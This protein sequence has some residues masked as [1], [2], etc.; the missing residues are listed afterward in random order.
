MLFLK[1]SLRMNLKLLF[2][3]LLIT[4]AIQN[5]E[6]QKVKSKPVDSTKVM[7]Q[8][9]EKNSKKSKFKK[10]VHKLI[11]TSTS[12]RKKPDNTFRDKVE[13]D[14]FKNNGKIVRNIEI[15][16]LDPFGYSIEDEDRQPNNSFE[17][18]GNKIHVKSKKW[19]IR[20]QI[21]F[22]K[23]EPLDSFLV[24]E[25]ERL[26]RKQRFVRNVIIKVVPI[27]NSND[28]IDV[29]I[30]V[31]DS[32]SLIPNGS[33]SSSRM[34]IELKERN[35]AGLGHEFEN[36][37]GTQFDPSRNSYN[38]KYS[39]N[40]IKNSF[41]NTT[42][43][44][45]KTYNSDITKSARVERIFYSPVTRF[46]GGAFYENRKFTDSLPSLI[47]DFEVLTFQNETTDFWF[48]N[49]SKLFSDRSLDYRNTNFVATV[50]YKNLNYLKTASVALDPTQ[51]LSDEELYL[52][53]FG[54]S[55]RKFMQERYLFN[56]DLIEDVPFGKVYAIT[57]GF[58]NKNQQT[59]NYFGGKFSHGHFFTFGFLG[60]NV[61]MG[62]F[63]KNGKSEE[64]TIRIEA[65]YF[66]NLMHIG[67]WKV[68][69][70]IKPS[71]VL[72]INRDNSI[73][74][75]ISL[76]N[77]N[78]FDGFTNPLFNGDRKFTTIFQTQTYVPGA[79]KGFHFS[80]FVNASFGFLGDSNDTFLNGKLYSNFTLGVLISNDYLVFN[81]FQISMSFYPTIPFEGTNAFKTNTF[82]NDDFNLP[83]YSIGQ[84]TIVDFK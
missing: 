28:S 6:A 23:N 8:N 4:C 67:D 61:E 75:K 58:Q 27:E 46:A 49:A 40:G 34:N 41:I 77:R 5:A 55:T 30:R 21:L 62:S 65:S 37:F 25:S 10:F 79:W 19:T 56:Y 9:L 14:I 80:P 60:T 71:L 32:W 83:D 12:K 20:N 16:T 66:T 3:F 17:R 74:D 36:D 52:M 53:S 68:R 22:K 2:Y 57:A 35:F 82:K 31:L 64:T 42:L 69:Q 81:R 73:K 33:I 1:L 38:G 47:P 24:E 63:F 43:I 72:G 50:G 11:F 78:G 48:G 45:N 18:F 51:F 7:Y 15:E 26:I 13:N 76:I 29:S 59:R 44:Y 39:L 70:F 84:P 54:I